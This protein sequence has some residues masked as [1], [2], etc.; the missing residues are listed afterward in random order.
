M[1]F[2]NNQVPYET[3]IKHSKNVAEISQDR[4]IYS[5]LQESSYPL[6]FTAFKVCQVTELIST[7][8]LNE[9]IKEDEAG[10]TF[11]GK[12]LYAKNWLR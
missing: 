3:S 12:E 11:L 1:Q 8:L 6:E 5:A 9:Y 4:H 10:N 2:F 7:I